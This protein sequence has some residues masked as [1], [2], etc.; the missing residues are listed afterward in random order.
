[1]TYEKVDAASEGMSNADLGLG[2]S[3][4]EVQLFLSDEPFQMIY[5]VF[6]LSESRIERAGFDAMLK[7]EKQIRN[8]IIESIKQ[9]ALEEGVDFQNPEI[10]ITYPVIGDAAILGEGY[11]SS[12]GFIIGFDTLWF[13]AGNAYVFLYSAYY[14]LERKALLPIAEQLEQRLAQYSY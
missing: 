4:S 6:A 11:F 9:G 14:S 7:D 13:R 1:M 5:G 3:F 8:L 12:S 2:P 10:Q